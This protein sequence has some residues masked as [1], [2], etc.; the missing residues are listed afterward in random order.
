MSSHDEK[1]NEGRRQCSVAF[2]AVR[3]KNDPDK[4][5][6]MKKKSAQPKCSLP[7]VNAHDVDVVPGHSAVVGFI[8]VAEDGQE[9][10]PPHGDLRH[11]RQELNDEE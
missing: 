3:N 4:P 2:A 8:V 9:F 5:Q 10:A 11:V 6:R 1:K 7:K